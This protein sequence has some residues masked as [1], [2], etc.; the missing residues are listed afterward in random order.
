MSDATTA[1]VLI[2]GAGPTGLM[3]ATVLA[4]RGITARLVD[5]R[6]NTHQESR[7]LAL[8]ARTLEVFDD[9][10]L[11]EAAIGAG[12]PMT[13]VELHHDRQSVASIGLDD[14][15]SPFPFG[16]CLPQCVTE[17][18]L[19]GHLAGQGVT[20]EWGVEVTGFA[21]RDDHVEVTLTR[22]DGGTET[23]R[24]RWLAGCDG[25]HS[26]V[27]RTAGIG[28]HGEDL[29]RQWVLADCSANWD[30]DGNRL[31][32]FF[33]DEGA[34]A[35][36]P[37]PEENG[38][39]VLCEYE[40]SSP[41]PTPPLEL[42]SK[43]VSERTSLDPRLYACRWTTY[44]GT[45]QRRADTFRSGRVFVAGDAAHSHSVIGGQGMNTGL[46]D[47]YNLGWKL[48][49]V[50]AGKAG[51]H[52]LDS[53]SH[54]RTR[55]ADGVLRLTGRATKMIT[56]RGVPASVRKR[57]AGL[58]TQLKGVQETVTR[59]ISELAIDYRTSPLV[60]DRW[61]HGPEE[62]SWGQPVPHAG[63]L[64]PDAHVTASQGIVR[65][66]RAL[67]PGGHTVLVFAGHEADEERLADLR[68][69]ARDAVS[70]YGDARV[71]TRG[72]LT[73]AVPEG[74]LFDRTG[75]V[76]RRYGAEDV[77]AVHLVRPDHYLGY[78]DDS[79]DFARLE[80]HLSGLISA[81]T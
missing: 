20:P 76:H 57:M 23:V 30:L 5:K 75:E 35:A 78:R 18:L 73:A 63:D 53:Y 68:K 17:D 34:F 49:L 71:V 9:L 25:A 58:V 47:A 66:R 1:D 56:F 40:G 3:L 62:T 79:H 67:H 28:S 4:R 65:L 44:F 33:N 74:V 52:V 50:L 27:R 10:G 43:L 15:E 14:V 6:Q 8:A 16:L 81:A 46:Q 55:V 31:H 21:E 77:R 22:A 80:R 64:S 29:H 60:T 24:T 19:C 36:I 59:G 41:G 11:A 38:W 51:T 32:A 42:V 12:R 70:G 7:A 26:A 39:R 13:A 48:A 72:P 54:E 61:R 69:R 2:A 37:L 45:R